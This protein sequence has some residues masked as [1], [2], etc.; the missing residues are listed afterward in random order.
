[1][2]ISFEDEH[3]GIRIPFYINKNK[4]AVIILYRRGTATITGI[5]D[6]NHINTVVTWLSEIL[7]KYKDKISTG[8]EVVKTIDEDVQ[9]LSKYVKPQDLFDEEINSIISQ[10]P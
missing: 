9:E 6:L 5:K 1:M 2:L 4:V 10:I 3:P 7:Y 8:T